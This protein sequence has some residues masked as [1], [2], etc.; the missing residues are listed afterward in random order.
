[1]EAGKNIKGFPV[2]SIV[3]QPVLIR[4]KGCNGSVI[5]QLSHLVKLGGS[6]N[7]V[8]ILHR[9]KFTEFSTGSK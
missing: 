4:K 6:R 8:E 2:F 9:R 5:G 3:K 1:M 7:K